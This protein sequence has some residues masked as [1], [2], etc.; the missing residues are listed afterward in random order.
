MN[1]RRI[2]WLTITVVIVLTLL[3]FLLASRL[4][5]DYDFE[6]FFPKNDNE[7]DFYF[8]FRE[9]FRTDNDFVLVGIKNEAG[10]FNSEFMQR[11][12]SLATALSE[13]DNVDAVF[14]PTTF[15]EPIFPGFGPPFFR[16]ILNIDDEE[17]LQQDSARVL[18]RPEYVGFFFS[19]DGKSVGLQV[20]H[21]EFLNKESCDTLGFEIQELVYNGGFDE[22]HAIGRCIGQDIYIKTMQWE[23]IIFIAVSMVLITIFLFIAFRS[24]WGIVVP[25]T[26][27]LLAISW[28]L[29]VMY[30]LGQQIDLMLTI[31]PTIMFVVG[32]SDVV[33]IVSKY[34]EELRSGQ[35]KMDALKVTFKE[36]GAATFL[37]SLTTAIG[38]LTL[39][40]SSISP[41]ANFG[42]YTAIGVF[43][44]YILAFSLL[45]SI[46]VLKK[47]PKLASLDPRKVFWSTTLHRGFGWTIRNKGLI[48]VSSTVLILV[49]AY[50]ISK[51]E[52]NNYI[53]E[54][55]KED[56]FLKQEFNYFADNFAGARP[57]E[58]A[59]TYTD[60][61]K[62]F[63]LE[64]LKKVERIEEYLRTDYGSGGLISP[65][66]IFSAM[67]RSNHGGSDEQ[68]RLPDTQREV[69]K[70]VKQMTRL[71]ERNPLEVVCN[72]EDSYS[73]IFGKCP[74]IGKIEYDKK[75]AAFYA[76]L[77]SEFD[78]LP[79]EATLTGTG[80]LID[81]N[82][83]QLSSTML[84]G[85]AI[86]FIVVA[87]ITMI[88]FKSWK[89]TLISLIPNVLP[90]VMIAAIMG[91]FGI[92][93]K[94]STAIIFSIAFGIA[95]DDTIHFLSKYRIMLSKG[96]SN[97]YALKRT[98]ISTGKAIVVTS[99]ILIAGFI[100]LIFSDFLGTFYI[101]LLIS[102][103]LLFAVLADLFLLPVLII[104]FFKPKK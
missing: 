3:S 47:T 4:T 8:D 63:D 27:V 39:M 23:M 45:P 2:S 17:R 12:D 11:F 22:A 100:S 85:L 73:R 83:S 89:M 94:A 49:C 95:V 76:F 32:M 35:P 33:H 67:H 61:T 43:L 86:A 79:F 102:L 64:T 53:L 59:I 40:T 41:I 88:M 31:L 38:F 21:K 1:Y 46:L 80:H 78:D 60:S 19:P 48:L 87:L 93:L 68:Y 90:L 81:L 84:Q 18:S 98:Y 44:A 34:F 62:M 82:N 7:S 66:S 74:D 103:T 69:D 15:E 70:F 20:L 52:V 10:V 91:Y 16:P 42:L 58:L 55:L 101:G 9:S 50:G 28:N 72:P 75:N 97:L 96:A 54:D 29:G 71:G 26:V 37:T 25:L 56:H 57:F 24:G 6:K 13:L 14:S 65:V 5:F 36:I 77:E 92:Y 30:V 51:V 99:L 104:L